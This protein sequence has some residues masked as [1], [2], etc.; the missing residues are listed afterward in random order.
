[1]LRFTS[2]GGGVAVLA[3]W[4]VKCLSGKRASII[5]HVPRWGTLIKLCQHVGMIYAWGPAANYLQEI[6][7]V[8][9]MIGRLQITVCIEGAGRGMP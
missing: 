9:I 6:E 3:T 2:S 5:I 8:N 4:S 7:Y 1:M